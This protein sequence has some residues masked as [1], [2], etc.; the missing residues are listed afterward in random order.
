MKALHE[1][2]APLY[3]VEA[4]MSALGAAMFGE[5]PAELVLKLVDDDD[6]YFPAHRDIY[7][8]MRQLQMDNK[9]I[10]MVTVKQELIRRGK[11]EAV[12]GEDYLIAVAE[13]VP[14]P[15]NAETY[16]R[17]VREAATLRRLEAAGHEIVKVVRGPDETV[18]E[19]V[20]LAEH[21]V[22]Q[23]G[24]R[25]MGK[26]F[27]PMPNLAADVM[28]DLDLILESGSET[29]G[30]TT[31]FYDLDEM[32]Q[33]FHPG[34]F[35]I[36]AAR[37]SMGKTA[38]VLSMALHVAELAA[39]QGK[40]SVAFFSLEMSGK[41]LAK[42]LVSMLSRISMHSM[43][44]TDL[45]DNTLKQLADACEHLYSLP[46]Y[47]DE[48]SDTTP[49][50]ALA[51]CRRLQREHGLSLVVVD[52]LQLMRYHRKTENRVQEISEIARSLKAMAKE[53]K[54][55]VIAL[56]QLNRSVESRDKK[57]PQLSDLRESGSIEAEADVVGLIYREQYYKDRESP[58]EARREADHT[59]V[60]SIIIAK[61][62]N[63]PTGF[64]KLGFQAT[65]ARFVNIKL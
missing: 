58:D 47:V 11:L 16:A 15:A 45:N 65:Y 62:R 35:V 30:I 2:P 60:A 59:E 29:L 26:E 19:K 63:G 46:I 38:L 13:F 14:T 36:I 56:S 12:G 1:G 4:E 3:S 64:V 42:R 17:L 39:E 7:V 22:Y 27:I 48:T 23:V 32:V 24:I 50:D 53:L 55:P 37:P 52:Y 34:D 5:R 54:V 10:D 40:G 18:E 21:K 51:K 43:R 8:A 9:P 25:E 31:G 28:N 20:K 33:G 49:L 44:R 41:Q 57:M 6:W 61:H